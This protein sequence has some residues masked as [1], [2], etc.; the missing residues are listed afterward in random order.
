MRRSAAPSVRAAKKLKLQTAYLA[1]NN[2]NAIEN[3]KKIAS[4]ALETLQLAG[5]TQVRSFSKQY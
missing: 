2:A 5:R 4:T 1:E 3:S